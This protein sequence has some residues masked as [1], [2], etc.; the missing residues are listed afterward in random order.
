MCQSQAES[1]QPAVQIDCRVFDAATGLFDRNSTC[2]AP[3][4]PS[5]CSGNG[6]VEL[7]FGSPQYI[8]LGAVVFL[9]LILLETFGSPFMR[10]CEVGAL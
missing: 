2:F 6:E 3:P 5:L 10:N 8:G 7:L 1:G 9:V 4:E